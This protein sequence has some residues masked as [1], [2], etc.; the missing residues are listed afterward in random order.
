MA[1]FEFHT[2]ISYDDVDVNMRLSLHGAMSMMQEAAI[3]H[4][5][6]IGYSVRNV[7]QTHVIW[8]LI[9]WRIRMVSDGEWN[10]NVIVR[11]WPRTMEKVSSDREFEIIGEDGRSIAI[12]TSSWV[13][14]ST[15]TGRIIRIPSEVA[16]AYELI[17][18]CLFKDPVPDFKREEGKLAYACTVQRRDIDTNNHVNNRVYLQYANEALGENAVDFRE[19]FVRYRK[20]LLLDQHVQCYCYECDPYHVV[21]IFSEDGQLSAT[22]AYKANRR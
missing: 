13:L 12:G 21:N 4:S 5:D 1:V 14:V 17:P 19:V 7:E 16:Q 9:Q 10:E 22:V 15:Q 2:R 6:Q 18:Q 3:I 8:M 11:T 20:Q